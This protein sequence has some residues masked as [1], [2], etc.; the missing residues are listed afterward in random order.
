MNSRQELDGEVY[1][2]NTVSIVAEQGLVTGALAFTTSWFLSEWEPE[3]PRFYYHIAQLFEVVDTPTPTLLETTLSLLI[4]HHDLLRVRIHGS[5]GAWQQVITASDEVQLLW[6]DLSRIAPVEHI[7]LIEKAASDLHRVLNPSTGSPLCVMYFDRGKEQHGQLLFII[8][9]SITDGH[10][11]SILYNDLETIYR[12]VKQ[13]TKISLP[14]KTVSFKRW[15]E[16]V[17][18]YVHELQQNQDWLQYY[19]SLPWQKLALFPP[20]YPAYSKEYIHRPQGEFVATVDRKEIDT[21]KKWFS[22]LKIPFVEGLLAALVHAFARWTGVPI[23]FFM[24]TDNGRFIFPQIDITRTVGP[25]ACTRWFLLDLSDCFLPE[26]MLLRTKQQMLS[27]PNRGFD[28]EFAYNYIEDVKIQELFHFIF[29]CQVHFNFQSIGFPGMPGAKNEQI[30]R[31]IAG[32]VHANSADKDTRESEPESSDAP[33]SRDFKISCTGTLLQNAFYF[34]WRYDANVY[35]PA[36]IE[37]IAQYYKESLQEFAERGV[38][39][40]RKGMPH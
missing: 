16:Y 7:T 39:F 6:V 23:L 29:K 13:G 32:N 15:S 1:P 31:P 33:P 36:T 35:L 10:S 2:T 40:L 34:T 37:K 21:L 17:I 28:L 38:W 3:H 25:F 14:G 18:E 12:Q 11:Q 4:K 24:L 30:L 19:L 26:D 8:H 27:L 5:K 9:H 22:M 20:D